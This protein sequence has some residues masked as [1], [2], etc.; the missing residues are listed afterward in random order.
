[1]IQYTIYN[2][3]YRGFIPGQ[4]ALGTATQDHTYISKTLT[5]QLH[6]TRIKLLWVLKVT[7]LFLDHS[8]FEQLVGPVY[9]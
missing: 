8:H 1:M 6:N 2:I 9:K 5:P 4:Y 3:Q 7:F